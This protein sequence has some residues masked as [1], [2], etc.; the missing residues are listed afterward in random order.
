MVGSVVPD[1]SFGCQKG[2]QFK[3]I[4]TYHKSYILPQKCQVPA[5]KTTSVLAHVSILH[6]QLHQRRINK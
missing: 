1:R 4:I 2:P 3:W 6:K 5:T